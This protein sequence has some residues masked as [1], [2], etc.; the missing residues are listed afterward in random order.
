MFDNILSGAIQDE[1][2]TDNKNDT[3]IKGGAVSVPFSVSASSDADNDNK[4]NIND[5]DGSTGGAS[6]ADNINEKSTGAGSLP[7]DFI[8]TLQNIIDKWCI[9]NAVSDLRKASALVWG[10]VC[11]YIGQYIKQNKILWNID[12]SNASGGV[13]VYDAE[14]ISDLV[15]IWA[16]LCKIYSKTPLV[17][18]FKDFSGLSSG[19][20]Y[21]ANGHSKLTSARGDFRKKV[22]EIQQG[23]IA[24]GIVDGRENPTGKIYFSKA[25][26]GWSENGITRA[27]A[28]QENEKNAGLPDL[29]A[30]MLPKMDEK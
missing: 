20:F 10:A 29:A 30:L 6:D 9:D 25:V 22:F 24:S 12:K 11:L 13:C 16:Y 2:K 28:M 18:D 7:F 3:V 1:N 21:N 23:A 17:N 5:L 15:D 4:D 26:L 27:D 19:Y 14:K 8:T